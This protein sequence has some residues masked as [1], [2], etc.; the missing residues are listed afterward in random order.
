[1]EVLRQYAGLCDDEIIAFDAAVKEKLEIAFDNIAHEA[2]SSKENQE[3]LAVE[4][5]QTVK[6]LEG[7]LQEL[8]AECD[9]LREKSVEHEN[10]LRS[11]DE[12]SRRSYEEKEQHRSKADELQTI[13]NELSFAVRN[14]ENEKEMLSSQLRCKIEH[15]EDL[16]TEIK[17]LRAETESVHKLKIDTML[18]SED[19]S[20][21]EAALKAQESRWAEECASMQR[22]IEWLEGRLRQTTDQ[23][24][25]ARRDTSQKCCTL[26][27][28]LE[29]RKIELEHAKETIQRLEEGTKK[30]TQANENY[31]EKLK[32]VADEQ[33]RLEQLYGNELEAQK[34]LISLYKE[35]LADLEEKN[36]ELTEAAGSMQSMLRSA[37][38]NVARLESEKSALHAQHSEEQAKQQESSKQLTIELERSRQLLDKFRVDGLSEEELRQLNPAVAAT[39]SALKRGHSLTQLYTDYVQIVEDRD[40]LRLD[41]QRLTEYVKQLVDDVKEKAPMLREQQE[42]YKRMKDE[43]KDLTAQLQ[44]VT[45]KLEESNNQRLELQR[46]A[47]YYQRE[48][49]RLKHTCGDL[50]KQVQLLLREIEVS[51]GT[52]IEQPTLDPSESNISSPVRSAPSPDSSTMTVNNATQLLDGIASA[53]VV[54]GEHLVTWRNLQELQWQNQRLLG[55]ARDLASQLE[56]REQDE[57]EASKRAN[58]LSLRLES[59]SGEL[60]VVR[61]AA[62]E[63]RNDARMSSHQR[64]LYRSLLKRYDIEVSLEH[65]LNESLGS[66]ASSLNV[67]SDK[68]H[69]KSNTTITAGTIE[70]MEETLSS[71]EAEFKRY[72]DNKTESDKIYSTTIEQLR[73]E[74]NEARILNQKLASQLDFTHEK[75]RTVEANVSGYKQEIT[76]LREMNARYSTSAAASEAELVRLREDLLR[77]SD[78]LLQVEV[79][80]RQFSRQLEIAR[81]N[82]NR[83]RQEAEALRRQEQMHTQL[84]RQLEAIQGN[85]EQRDSVDRSIMEK[86]VGQLELQLSE[87][88]S[89]FTEASQASKRLKE[90]LEHELEVSK[91]KATTAESEVERLQTLVTSLERELEMLKPKK[92]TEADEDGSSAEA[93]N[94]DSP[95]R[96]MELQ[97]EVD[98]LRMRVDAAREQADKMRD[99]AENAELRLNEMMQETQL[100]QERLGSELEQT[101]Q[102]CEFLE[103]QLDLEKKERQNLVNENIRTTEEAHQ[104]NAELRRQLSNL[105][106]ELDSIRTR[107]ESAL[108][109]EA[110]AKS[111]IEAHER[112]AQE[113]RLKYERELSLHAEDVEALT[114]AR[115]EVDNWKSKLADVQRQLT[116]SESRADTVAKEL[117]EMSRS[118]DTERQELNEKLNLADKDQSLMQD[119]IIKLTQ[120]LIALRKLMEKPEETTEPSGST[121]QL[122]ISTEAGVTDL[123]A[124]EDLLQLVNYLRRQKSIAEATCDAS[125]A[126]VSRLLLRVASLESQKD[127]LQTELE[128]ERR[129]SE[130]AAETSQRHSELMERVEQLNLVTESNRLLRHERETLQ[131]NLKASEGQ[132]RDLE[133]LVGPLRSENSELMAQVNSLGTEKHSLEEERDRWKERCNRLVETAQRM[134]PEQYRMACNERDELQR[135]LRRAEEEV[136]QYSVKLNES[137]TELNEA[138]KRH[139]AELNEALASRQATEEE[140]AQHRSTCETLR[141]ELEGKETTVVKLREIGRKYRQEAET[142]RRQLFANQSD[143]AQLQSLNE[144]LTEAKADVVTL[145]SDLAT[146]RSERSHLASVITE[147]MRVLNTAKANEHLGQSFET[148][149]L[150]TADGEYDN[151]QLVEI[152]RLMFDHLAAEISQLR[153]HAEMQRE[154]LL[155]MQLVESQLTKAQR[156]CAELRA[157]LCEMQ[158]A[159]TSVSVPSAQNTPTV[160]V[161]SSASLI[162]NDPEPTDLS[163]T[164]QS[165]PFHLAPF[166][167]PVS[168]PDST[169]TGASD[170]L[171]PVAGQNTQAPAASVSTST[172]LGGQS[173]PAWILRAS[174]TVQPVQPTPA[175]TPPNSVVGPKQTAEIRPI[176]SNVAT[177][178]PTPAIQI[179][180]TTSV[181]A[182]PEPLLIPSVPLVTAAVVTA[183][184]VAPLSSTTGLVSP[185]ANDQLTVRPDQ[186]ATAVVRAAQSRRT[187]LVGPAPPLGDQS[188][189]ASS[190]FSGFSWATSTTHAPV[191]SP[192]LASVTGKRRHEDASAVSDSFMVSSSEETVTSNTQTDP[193]RLTEPVSFTP[194]ASVPAIFSEAKRL[195]PMAVLASTSHHLPPAEPS[196]VVLER[197]AFGYPTSLQPLA[198][199]TAS[200]LVAGQEGLADTWST[201]APSAVATPITARTPSPDQ[202]SV[203]VLSL[204]AVAASPDLRTVDED[205]GLMSGDFYGTDVALLSDAQVN[206]KHESEITQEQEVVALPGSGSFRSEI[207]E[208]D[209]TAGIEITE[210]EGTTSV[211]TSHAPTLQVSQE[212]FERVRPVEDSTDLTSDSQCLAEH[213]SHEQHETEE[214]FDENAG[215]EPE[216]EEIDEDFEHEIERQYE[217]YDEE[218][219]SE[220]VSEGEVEEEADEVEDE[221]QDEDYGYGQ[222]EPVETSMMST[223]ESNVIELSSES[224]NNASREDGSEVG[225]E[226]EG[227]DETVTYSRVDEPE[228]SEEEEKEHPDVSDVEDD[229]GLDELGE[230]PAISGVGD[231]VEDD[232]DRVSQEEGEEEHSPGPQGK[233]PE[234]AEHSPPT[235]HRTSVITISVT[236]Q[237]PVVT[238]VAPTP[239]SSVLFSSATFGD[240]PG[241]GL[242]GSFDPKAPITGGLF[243]GFRPSAAI[244]LTTGDQM[245]S[246][247]PTTSSTTMTPG[248]FRSS[249]LTQASATPVLSGLFKPSLFGTSTIS[250]EK[251]A[252]SEGVQ[253][254]PKIQPIVW[255]APESPSTVQPSVT[256]TSVPR[257]GA[258]RRKKWGGPSHVRPGSYLGASGGTGA[259][260]PDPFGPSRGGSSGTCGTRPGPRR[261]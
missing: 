57:V 2:T 83:W 254:K 99:L 255:D 86:R 25:T 190:S 248:L 192:S 143:G 61:L 126:E 142:L 191:S 131:A 174:A 35:Q 36:T 19:V 15:I 149:H 90:T 119:Q 170:S 68:P 206:E 155:R 74:G 60:E 50:S 159:P 122:P 154:R 110:G 169:V 220:V 209:T 205:Q 91:H 109:L 102:R 128:N 239:S 94:K 212:E 64:D 235:M 129:A 257:I 127:H 93:T 199:A 38:E 42:K 6:V 189:I 34:Q 229:E 95:S 107:C 162:V 3:R 181:A 152:I 225:E 158:S 118:W 187:N 51:R 244:G 76:V 227:E 123:K 216:E 9:R 11:A 245:P 171:F 250:A 175:V 218:Q 157:R 5:A 56:Q 98:S 17:T 49:A 30:L 202:S 12:K 164:S 10:L 200:R 134:D 238:N 259:S 144:A 65:T 183:S 125:A 208:Q 78:K 130:L 77:T 147:V 153:Q 105:Q 132:V 59:L 150:P 228:Q 62:Q 180:Q 103:A 203:T 40:Q 33:I 113:A 194:Y 81:A 163:Q 186:P 138:M 84:M 240:K 140:C 7:Q 73:K 100:L 8:G 211:D 101:T 114:A 88:Q 32:Q 54:I 168:C 179:V 24:L 141:K 166:G 146:V 16:S 222:E 29:S 195:R 249:V 41:K 111:V 55:V 243:A 112:A 207:R 185:L 145:R 39:L 71:L 31:I 253:A 165:F 182:P 173:V 20:S 21:R 63:A 223:T 198:H 37:Y 53:S 48:V 97:H 196:A 13:N 116:T 75:L 96:Q 233:T 85:L 177:V 58:E 120:Q 43:I 82:E 231:D 224:D 28:E 115:Q 69:D 89:A 193:N 1:M 256:E 121:S 176:T 230:R 161:P 232:V 204:P 66:D 22:H 242:F 247:G 72:R 172:S 47:G 252:T 261:G 92:G 106:G 14:L 219:M 124:S 221:D 117:D 258:A 201:S 133:A 79:D 104:L 237:A 167:T 70:R 23:L 214:Q 135:Q 4:H 156:D 188:A 160:I 251:P 108:E 44:S 45:G 137:R 197:S 52:V 210:S 260:K 234:E 26:E 27:S 139:D 213:Y 80:A 236:S 184:D 87:A 246:S 226:E 217:E 151:G 215:V 241:A 178:T 148:I 67:T 136:Q 46:R 18:R